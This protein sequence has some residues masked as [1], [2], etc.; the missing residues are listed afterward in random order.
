MRKGFGWLPDLP[1]HGDAR[2]PDWLFRET[3]TAQRKRLETLPDAHSNAHLVRSIL[4]QDGLGSC[5]PCAGFQAL[6]MAQIRQG[7]KEARLGARLFSYYL[8]RS[9]HQLAAFDAG[10][11][12]RTFFWSL[13]RF[14]FLYEDEYRWGYDVTK[15]AEAPTSADYRLAF[16]QKTP[17]H[18]WSIPEGA[19][20]VQ[21]IKKAV[22]LGLG[23]CFGVMV[24]D[25]F[26][27]GAIDP[28]KPLDPP[29]RGVMNGHAMLVDGYKGDTFSIVNSWGY[30]FGDNGRCLFSADYLNG[31]HSIWVVESTPKAT[32]R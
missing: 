29:R 8:C 14:G 22:A 1:K 30:D 10:A 4:D 19:D 26:A 15:F 24:D 5:V 28:T 16:D 17:T 23:V 32:P 12:L 2:T 13:N 21:A 9:A 18:F 3:R 7:A 31:A 20:R 27:D 11:Q 6:R 25:A